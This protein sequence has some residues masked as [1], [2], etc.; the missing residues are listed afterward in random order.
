LVDVVVP[1]GPDELKTKKKAI[2]KHQSQK[3]KAMF[4]GQDKREFW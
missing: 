3:D 1:M 2:F 4:P